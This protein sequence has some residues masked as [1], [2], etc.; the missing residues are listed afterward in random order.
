M[1]VFAAGVQYIQAGQAPGEVSGDF[2]HI[3]R[4]AISSATREELVTEEKW[5]RIQ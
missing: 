1:N 5:R 2:A 4:L 3:G